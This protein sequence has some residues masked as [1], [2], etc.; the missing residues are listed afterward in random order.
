MRK[1]TDEDLLADLYKAALANPDI[2][3]LSG[4]VKET[5]HGL[6]IYYDHFH[7]KDNI[8]TILYLKYGIRIQDRLKIKDAEH[9]YVKRIKDYIYENNG[10]LPTCK[11]FEVYSGL[12]V[13]SLNTNKDKY[14]EYSEL[15]YKASGK[16]I[17]ISRKAKH[18]PH[19]KL[20]IQEL[21]EI[22]KNLPD[23]TYVTQYHIRKIYSQKHNMA[24]LLKIFGTF[25]NAL[26]AAK[27]PVSKRIYTRKYSKEQYINCLRTV[28]KDLGHC[29]TEKE[30]FAHPL[31]IGSS[32]GID[33]CFGSWIKALEAAG[34]Q[35]N[36]V[37]SYTDKEIIMSIQ[38][39]AKELKHR[40]SYREYAKAKGVPSM[41]AIRNHF[42][43]WPNALE[44]AGLK[45]KSAS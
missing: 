18:I 15:L 38:N 20:I 14:I 25:K 5:C 43:S 8:F 26:K 30:Y 2:S 37:V 24:L 36:H 21:Q 13:N 7:S 42:G 31:S 9:F 28:A 16:V 41:T 22:Y 4:L 32:N 11:E 10:K 35:S 19:K 34:L 1:L 27:I 29:P 23:K 39:R 3:D 12:Y 17:R 40:P 44:A 45:E 6:Q 33:L